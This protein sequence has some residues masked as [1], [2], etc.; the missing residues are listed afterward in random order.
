MDF[1]DVNYCLRCGTQLVLAERYGRQ[2]KTC[3]ACDWVY[4]ADP[5]V[6]VATLIVQ[7]GKVLLVRRNINPNRG[8]WTLPAGFVDAGE[9][10]VHAAKRECLEEAGVQVKVSGLITVLFG[11][12]H[13]RGAHIIIFY[14]ADIVSGKLTPGDD[15]DQVAF[16]DRSSLPPLAFQSTYQVL[17]ILK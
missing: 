6:A 2:R 13:P 16:F 17:N 15:V 5:K 1:L 4:F 10:P 8:M 7:D 14:Q 9:D 11:Q 3:P 12:E